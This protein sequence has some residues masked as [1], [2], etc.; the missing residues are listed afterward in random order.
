MTRLRSMR[1]FLKYETPKLENVGYRIP[2]ILLTGYH[3]PDSIP[4]RYHRV[5]NKH[6]FL[7]TPY[8]FVS[9]SYL[10]IK[11]YYFRVNS[12][13]GYEFDSRTVIREGAC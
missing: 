5:E 1:M 13:D 9:E 12:F 7:T 2:R 11:Y 6:I 10:E 8:A 3:P 4:S